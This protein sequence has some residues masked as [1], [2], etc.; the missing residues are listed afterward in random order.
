MPRP[1]APLL[2]LLLVVCAAAVAGGDAGPPQSVQLPVAVA[3]WD[4]KGCIGTAL[5]ML[6]R[7]FSAVDAAVAGCEV[8]EKDTAVH[9]VGYGGSPD[10]NGETTLDALV[11]DGKTMNMGAVGALRFVREAAQVA[12]LVL[13]HTTH[14]ML[15]GTQ[16]TDFATHFGHFA[17][18]SLA[19][20]YSMDVHEKWLEGNCQP[21]FYAATTPDPASGCPPFKPKHE[22]QNNITIGTPATSQPANERTIQQPTN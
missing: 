8:A 10:Q 21:N 12:K 22:D 7:N 20:D 9:S 2:Q 16:A 14:T 11:T 3:G 1:A 19:T 17:N 18:Q 6:Q 4:C 13:R 5:A 15:A